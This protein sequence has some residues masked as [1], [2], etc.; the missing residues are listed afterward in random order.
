MPDLTALNLACGLSLT[1]ESIDVNS[2]LYG[3]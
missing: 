2:V 3:R 1:H